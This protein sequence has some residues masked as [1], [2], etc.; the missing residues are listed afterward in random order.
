MLLSDNELS[1]RSAHELMESA[2]W[3]SLPAVRKGCVYVLNAQLWNYNDAKTQERM[4]EML[5]VVLKQDFMKM[6]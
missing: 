6:G 1:R 2:M 4:L 3:Q 5:P